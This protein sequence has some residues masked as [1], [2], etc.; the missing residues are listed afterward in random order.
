MAFH[1]GYLL[2]DAAVMVYIHRFES[3]HI[4]KGSRI[5]SGS[6]VNEI[7]CYCPR[8]CGGNIPYISAY[9]GYH[10]HVYGCV[11]SSTTLITNDGRPKIVDAELTP[12][13]RMW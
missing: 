1:H 7:S 5:L 12:I 4:L 2:R 11:R 13:C 9:K 10:I 8:G 6:C 3:F